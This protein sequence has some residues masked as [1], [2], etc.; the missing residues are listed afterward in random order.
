MVIEATRRGRW[1]VLASL[2]A[3][4]WPAL[5]GSVAAQSDARLADAVMKRDGAAVRSLLGQK[6]D[7]NLP[8]KDGTPALHWSVR[9]DDVATARLLLGAGAD[10]RLANRYGVT[11]L[12]LACAN[13]NEAMI[14]LLLDAGADPNA[15][16]PTGE[17]PLM[18]AARVG[19]LGA[20]KLLLE[21]GAELDATDPAFQQ[22]ALMVAVRENHPDVVAFL[23]ER[24]ADVNAKTRTGGTPAFVLPNSVPGFGHGIG[25]VRGGLPARGLR[26]PIP[27]ALFPLLYA[28]RDGRLEIARTLVAAKADVNQADANGIT[29]LIAAIT[30]NHVDVAR[31]L[32]DHGADIK[33]SDW[34]GRTPL[35]AAIETRNMDFDNGTFQNS[36]DRKPFLELIQVLLKQAA[37]PNVRM[38]EVPPIRRQ[39]LRTTGSLSWVDFTGQTPFLTASLAGDLTVMRLLLEH[40]ADPHIPTFAGT[41]ALMAAA[42]VN[43]VFDQTYDEGPEALLEAVQL[44][45]KLG[46]D[47][48]AVNSMGLTA[49]HGAANRGSDDIIR[50]LVDKGAKLDVK[51]KEGRTPLNWAE[52]VFLATHPA[53]PKPSSI[54]L[55]Q[56]I[57]ASAK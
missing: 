57:S 23:V 50:F 29:P 47:V 15:A 18:A 21:R 36:I 51:D 56:G 33:A 46:M 10:A 6:V 20:V 32:I 17:T 35:W 19:T 31:F 30:N 24:G 49:L 26:N 37:D 27:G 12:F 9:E 48:N 16:D 28:A 7:V 5:G 44:C 53:K 22:T 8:G 3:V 55:L 25:I 2:L 43:W 1:L 54:E 41:T 11:P 42:G 13:G 34:Y 38:K 52:G 14:R 45:H 39:F 4:L 40:G